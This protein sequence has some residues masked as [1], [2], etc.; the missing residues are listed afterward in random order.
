MNTIHDHRLYWAKLAKQQ[1][2]YE[3]P[4]HVCV[5]IQSDGTVT[6]SVSYRGLDQDM[7]LPA[8]C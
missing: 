7:V 4:F 6:D 5:W 1:G 2:W 3:F 8:G